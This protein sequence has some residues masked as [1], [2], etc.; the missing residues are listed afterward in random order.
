MST[1]NESTVAPPAEETSKQHL[2]PAIDWSAP[3]PEY[4]KGLF[5]ALQNSIKAARY[6]VVCGDL[7]IIVI[8]LNRLDLLVDEAAVRLRDCLPPTGNSPSGSA[9]EGFCFRAGQV[10][11]R[12]NGTRTFRVASLAGD[13]VQIEWWLRGKFKRQSRLPARDLLIF[14]RENRI[15][16]M[17]VLE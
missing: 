10:W 12:S 15:R 7:E 5:T 13:A 8:L 4:L 14:V 16:P 11:G 2:Q 9:P 3:D 17:P 1:A 6:G